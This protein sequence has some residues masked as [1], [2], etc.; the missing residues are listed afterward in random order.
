[1]LVGVLALAYVAAA[2][3]LERSS[4]AVLGAVGILATTTYFSLDAVSVVSNVFLG[5]GASEIE[6]WQVA[7]WFVAA[8]LLIGGL[9][10]AGDGLGRLRSD[11]NEPRL[12]HDDLVPDA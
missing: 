11:R 6:P 9:G 12:D 4:Y 8:G 7:L 2:Y 3:W 10:L 1:V 5:G